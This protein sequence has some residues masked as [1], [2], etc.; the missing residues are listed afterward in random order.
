MSEELA[1]AITS[2][3]YATLKD[4]VA[5]GGV[6]LRLFNGMGGGREALREIPDC[7]LF[8]RKIIS[9]IALSMNQSA[10]MS[11]GWIRLPGGCRETEQQ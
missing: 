4:E 10:D 3:E 5:V 9:F 11:D 8:A 7:S 2:F 1:V 6:Y